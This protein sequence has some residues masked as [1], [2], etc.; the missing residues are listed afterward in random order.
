MT[1]GTSPGGLR[2]LISTCM[3]SSIL[4]PANRRNALEGRKGR[5]DLHASHAAP[6]YVEDYGAKRVACYRC[7][8]NLLMVRL[9]SVASVITRGRW[10]MHRQTIGP[11]L[12]V[13]FFSM[14]AP[15]FD[16]R[17]GHSDQPSVPRWQARAVMSIRPD[18]SAARDT[19]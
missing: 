17:R 18:E 13:V 4:A 15:F 1:V 9:H 16:S 2:C 5:F 11:L 19:F 3:A 8:C 14:A 12:I 7:G 6:H 10:W